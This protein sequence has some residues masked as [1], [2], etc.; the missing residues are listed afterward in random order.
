MTAARQHR[1]AVL[2]RATTAWLEAAWQPFAGAVQVQRLRPSETGLVMLR[3]RAG[4]TGAPFNLG[5]ASLCRC[6]VALRPAAS[7]ADP[8]SVIGVGYALGRDKRKAE[9][10]A[11]FEALARLPEH[12][13]RVEDEVLAP[14]AELQQ[15]ERSRRAERT[16]TSR[17]AFV[18]MVRGET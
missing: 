17:V 16:A 5:E 4:G 18:T 1:H 13:S 12:A 14:L 6:A 2:A 11:C 9:L 3:G 15:A 8:A 7:A 10:I